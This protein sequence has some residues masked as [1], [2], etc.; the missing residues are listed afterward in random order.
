MLRLLHNSLLLEKVAALHALKNQAEVEK[1]DGHGIYRPR[2]PTHPILRMETGARA[3]PF[4]SSRVRLQVGS[5][6]NSF[7]VSH[8]LAT[9]QHQGRFLVDA[10]VSAGQRERD[11]ISAENLQKN[12]NIY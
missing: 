8:V 6:K 2:K 11:P 1:R 3:T 9:F 7:C 4:S 12:K 5:T 10:T